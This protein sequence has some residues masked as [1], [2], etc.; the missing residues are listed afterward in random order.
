MQE[1]QLNKLISKILSGE[2]SSVEI[3]EFQNWKNLHPER[4]DE[5]KLIGAAWE[6]TKTKTSV[7]NL[8]FKFDQIR[9][10]IATSSS[11][12]SLSKSRRSL[13]YFEN[14]NLKPIG[15]AAS[16]VFLIG[17]LLA[18]TN[19]DILDNSTPLP[20]EEIV[21]IIEKSN[22]KGQK[23]RIHLS[24]GST[25]ILNSESTLRYPS[26]FSE[27]ERKVELIG[28]AYFDIAENPDKPFTVKSSN[29]NTTA[30]GTSFNIHAFPEENDIEVDLASGKV[31]VDQVDSPENKKFILTPGQGVIYNKT[32]KQSKKII[33]DPKEKLSWKDGIIDFRKAGKNEVFHMLSRWYGKEFQFT[34]ASSNWKYTGSFDNENLVNI[35]NSIGFTKN[36]THQ[37]KGDIVIITFKKSSQ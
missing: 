10:R 13:S 4:Q 1:S 9:A 37:I 31:L 23:L 29:I 20:A 2:A 8:D 35:L 14:F 32:S 5:I 25:V 24:D 18:I 21:Q 16:I 36:F 17:T 30:L 12:G 22:P 34:N 3:R 7:T 28:E 27:T 6:E 15:I 11:E 33:F 26:K 19:L